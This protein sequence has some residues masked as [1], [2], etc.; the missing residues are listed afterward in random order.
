MDAFQ[1]NSFHFFPEKWG[2]RTYQK[3]SFPVRYGQ[4]S[5]IKTPA[6]IFQFNLNGEI[7]FIQGRDRNWPHPSEWLKRTVTNDWLY[8]SAG[9]YNG[10]YDIIGEY[11]YPCLPYPTNSIFNSYGIDASVKRAALRS[12][13]GLQAELK[14]LM[15]IRRENG[16]AAVLTR[17]AHND[18]RTLRLRSKRH[19][20]L[21]GGRVR[22]LPPDTRHVDYEAIP[23]NIADGCL[24]HCDFCGVKSQKEFGQRSPSNI[25]GQIKNL[26]SFYGQDIRNFNSVYLGLH[27]ALLADTQLIEFAAQQ[28]FEIFEFDR[29]NLNNPHL[30][31][32]GSVES[33]LKSR[34][35]KFEM[36]NRLP[37]TT[38][39]NLG[40][41]SVD[42]GTLT[43]LGKPI[44]VAMVKDA[45]R[46]M[47]DINA[48]YGHIEISVNFV[49]GEKLP[50]R[51]L[52]SLMD[53][54]RNGLDRTR[55]KG[56][57]YLS[58]LLGTQNSRE[59]QR[60]FYLVK[61]MSRLPVYLYLIQRL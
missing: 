22:V 50:P 32:F 4:Y 14:S 3:L 47:L 12:W 33:I 21:T 15:P 61:N 23:V 59:M 19:F 54:L 13:E 40:L 20:S 39:V 60:Q 27:D 45:F 36:L 25:I 8:Y 30:F 7:K 46:R 52:S 2:C 57:V 26:K 16:S 18:A 38:Y 28:A 9:S 35:S 56:T 34:E 44:P 58:P 10:I 51:H 53:L 55:S 11:Y 24:Y 5:E 41:E 6:Y 49:M 43:I 37:F 31:L 42:A 1:F 17:I 48:A 29:S